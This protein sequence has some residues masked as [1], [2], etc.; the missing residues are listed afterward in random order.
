MATGPTAVLIPLGGCSKYE[1]PGG[2][3]IDPD[4]DAALFRAIRAGLRSDIP[5]HDVDAN[6]NDEAFIEAAAGAFLRLWSQA[7]PRM[8]GEI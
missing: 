7:R 2:P 5:C 4:A 3:F 8:D 6:I 1:L